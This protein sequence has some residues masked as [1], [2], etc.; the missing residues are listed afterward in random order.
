MNSLHR[1]HLDVYLS[2]ERKA[3]KK[4]RKKNDIKKVRMKEIKKGD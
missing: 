4:Q 3:S 2:R 1:R